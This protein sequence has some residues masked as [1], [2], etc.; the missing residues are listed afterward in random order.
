MERIQRP[1]LPSIPPPQPPAILPAMPPPA[2]LID[3]TAR[4]PTTLTASVGSFLDPLS[5]GRFAQTS[6][7]NLSGSE[8]ATRERIQDNFRGL[9]HPMAR[10]GNPQIRKD[11]AV[12][13][14]RIGLNYL[15]SLT[16][17]GPLTIALIKSG[18]LSIRQVEIEIDDIEAYALCPELNDDYKP[19]I[20]NTIYDYIIARH[21]TC[22]QVYELRKKL[23]DRA[24]ANLDTPTIQEC[25][26]K[27]Y[28][29]FENALDL[30]DSDMD[31]LNSDV[32]QAYVRKDGSFNIN[33]LLIRNMLN[34]TFPEY[35][36]T[37]IFETSVQQAI[38][39]TFNQVREHLRVA[40]IDVFGPY[41]TM[42]DLN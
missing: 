17:T 28:L 39:M 8:L 42:N 4:L 14:D 31:L 19:F 24:L 16:I 11:T 20:N 22:N 10:F 5:L 26:K 21:T 23:T 32:V 40:R 35:R 2:A 7:Y 18:A 37:I 13:I 30:T 25:I 12:P 1:F 6:K 27:G 41:S 29:T 15:T 34:Q 9:A 33:E 36:G 3:R 38:G